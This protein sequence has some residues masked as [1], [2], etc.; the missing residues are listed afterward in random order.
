MEFQMRIK[1]YLCL[2]VPLFALA[3]SEQP[4]PKAPGSEPG[5]MSPEGHEAAAEAESKESES[6]EKMAD[7]AAQGYGER[8]E[9]P[10]HKREAEKH[11]EFSKQHDAAA[12]KAAGGAPSK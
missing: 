11:E 4:A 1:K 9:V 12:D 7:D 8:A 5:D 2:F 6:H 10:E 3:C